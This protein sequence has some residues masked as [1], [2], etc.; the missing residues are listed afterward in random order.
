[1]RLSHSSVSKITAGQLINFLSN[2]AIRF[3]FGAP[4]IN[5][6]WVMPLQVAL[7]LYLVWNQVG[8]SSLAG[9]FTMFIITIPIQGNYKTSYMSKKYKKHLNCMKYLF[10]LG[11]LGVMSSNFRLKVANRSDT[12]VKHMTELINGIQVIKMYAWEKPFEKIIQALR[13]YEVAAIRGSSFL[14]AIYLS[15]IVFTDRL[16]LFTTITCYILLGH[17]IGADQVF[18][19]AQFY[20]VMQVSMACGF[21]LAINMGA[22]ILVSIRRLEEFLCLHEK[23]K[24]KITEDYKDPDMCVSLSNINAAWT[25][26]EW[27]LSNININIPFGSLCI[28]VGS[29][30]SGKSSILSM[31]LGELVPSSGIIRKCGDASYASQEPWLFVGSVRDNILFGQPYVRGRY[32]EVVRACALEKD[33]QL[34]PY[35]DKTLVGERGVALSGG[36][37]ARINLARAVYRQADIYLLDDPLSAVDTHVS[38]HLFQECITEYLGKKTRILVTHQ[39]Q[40]LN[41]ADYIVVVDDVST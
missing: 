34:F 23:E 26:N 38:K 10:I 37:R 1:M 11:F 41:R 25:P 24:S 29:V 6:I 8:I 31:I 20:N 33:F 4:W 40:F 5:F 30:G 36:Q 3:D 19:L 13:K 17:H 27:K 15:F 14:K 22:E 16:S 9:V 35:G 21:P 7:G 18:S 39:L 32:R 28:I 2:D 12:R